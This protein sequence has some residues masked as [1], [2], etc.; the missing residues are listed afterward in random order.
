MDAIRQFVEVKNHSFNVSLPKNF[1][2]KKVEVIIISDEK[3]ENE[4]LSDEQK[5][6]LDE[7]LKE[8]EKDCISAESSI[9]RLKQQY[10]L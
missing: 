7:R 4:E 9:H 8:N 6:I 10:G 2:A 1:R 3:E 5:A